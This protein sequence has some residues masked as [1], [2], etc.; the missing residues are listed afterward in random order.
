MPMSTFPL[1]ELAQAW[2]SSSLPGLMYLTFFDLSLDYFDFVLSFLVTESKCLP[3]ISLRLVSLLIGTCRQPYLSIVLPVFPLF[4]L[5]MAR[6]GI[7][8]LNPSD[9]DGQAAIFRHQGM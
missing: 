3:R 1:L 2:H 7:F 4:T 6:S 9:P 8:T 5:T